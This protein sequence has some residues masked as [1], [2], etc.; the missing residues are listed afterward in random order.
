MGRRYQR[1]SRR[2]SIA[3]LVYSEN[4]VSPRARSSR[5]SYEDEGVYAPGKIKYVGKYDGNA[6][7]AADSLP[8]FRPSHRVRDSRISKLC[9]IFPREMNGR[10]GWLADVQPERRVK[11]FKPYM[12]RENHS[13][14][15]GVVSSFQS[16]MRLEK[17]NLQ[18]VTKSFVKSAVSIITYKI[19]PNCS[20][21]KPSKL[22]YKQIILRS[23]IKPIYPNYIHG[24]LVCICIE[25]ASE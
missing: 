8:L 18:V 17:C 23:Y 7:A 14:H 19:V 9:E 1:L 11:F 12:I 3:H 22:F 5:S 10:L 20:K 2:R 24:A 6:Y 13:L 21:L 15:V 16:T 4:F 25:P